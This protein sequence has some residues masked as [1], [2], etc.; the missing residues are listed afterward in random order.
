MKSFKKSSNT[1]FIVFIVSVLLSLFFTGRSKIALYS[2][3]ISGYY[4][5]KFLGF[6]SIL[7][8]IIAFI[9]IICYENCSNIKIDTSK[10]D[11]NKLYLN[12]RTK[13]L[14]YFKQYLYLNLT[15]ESNENFEQD[16][17][18]VISMF[19]K[20]YSSYRYKLN[21][22]LDSLKSEDYKIE[23]KDVLPEYINTLYNCIVEKTLP[24]EDFVGV[25]DTTNSFIYSEDVKFI[26]ASDTQIYV[27]KDLLIERFR[28][29]DK[30]ALNV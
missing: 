13:F 30:K 2:F 12:G 11:L 19:K 27:L 7:A 18:Y 28:E 15:K 8:S 10:Q 1:S 20:E 24:A 23:E 4:G 5:F 22:I 25:I 3:N 14:K 6:L 26:F 29:L 16:L 21:D 9:C 17:D